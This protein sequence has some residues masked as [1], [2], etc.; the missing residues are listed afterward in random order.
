MANWDHLRPLMSEQCDADG[1]LLRDS[2]SNPPR[3]SRLSSQPLLS[4]RIK[5]FSFHRHH[6]CFPALILL[7]RVGMSLKVVVDYEAFSGGASGRSAVPEPSLSSCS[8]CCR[9]FEG[10]LW[11]S[12]SERGRFL[13]MVS[14]D[15]PCHCELYFPSVRWL[16]PRGIVVVISSPKF[17]F[18][19]N[20]NIR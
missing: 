2:Y 13:K 7:C 20:G 14:S 1:L 6:Y 5:L 18:L 3:S 12:W 9:R 19:V 15:F 16:I 8:R 17:G 10:W 11:W 4:H